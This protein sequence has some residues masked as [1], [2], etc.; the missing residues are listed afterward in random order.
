MPLVFHL[1]VCATGLCLCIREKEPGCTSVCSQQTC[2]HK[3]NKCYGADYFWRLS[4]APCTCVSELQRTSWAL[5]QSFPKHCTNNRPPTHTKLTKATRTFT[6]FQDVGLKLDLVCT[7]QPTG[8]SNKIYT[9]CTIHSDEC[10][11]SNQTEYEILA[12]CQDIFQHDRNVRLCSATH[13][14]ELMAQQVLIS[15]ITQYAR[16]KYEDSILCILCLAI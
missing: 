6:S 14:S 8:F 3:M 2:W 7:Y 1:Y 11:L 4:P 13:Q 10:E 12:V 15:G 16:Y 9:H 5:V